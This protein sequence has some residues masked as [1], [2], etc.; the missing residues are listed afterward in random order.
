MLL[1]W[2][3]RWIFS[4]HKEIILSHDLLFFWQ[5]KNYCMYVVFLCTSVI[6]ILIYLSIK[7]STELKRTNLQ[8]SDNMCGWIL[9]FLYLEYLNLLKYL[10]AFCIPSLVHC[11]FRFCAQFLIG[12]LV[13]ESLNF[14]S[15][16]YIFANSL[17]WDV[18]FANVFSKPIACLFILST[19]SFT[20]QSF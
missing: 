14:Y 15:S 13:F 10:F 12:L 6:A 9:N 16:S 18:S 3:K 8:F 19:V 17:L 4:P 20:A 7:V 11:L 5:A 1:A 2:D